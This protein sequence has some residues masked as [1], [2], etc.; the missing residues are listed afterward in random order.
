[1]PVLLRCLTFLHKASDDIKLTQLKIAHREIK[2][3]VKTLGFFFSFLHGIILV[4]QQSEP[5]GID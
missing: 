2:F 1:M 4:G 5:M 3:Q